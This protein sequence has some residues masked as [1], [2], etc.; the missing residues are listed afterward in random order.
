M[1]AKRTFDPYNQLMS[2]W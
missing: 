1:A 2:V